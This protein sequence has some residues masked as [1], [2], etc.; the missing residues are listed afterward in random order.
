[1]DEQICEVYQCG[2]KVAVFGNVCNKHL[3]KCSKEG[4]KFKILPGRHGLCKEHD[5]EW[6]YANKPDFMFLVDML[7]REGES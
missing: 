3:P 5:R 7:E 4:C 1:M 2:N 6:M